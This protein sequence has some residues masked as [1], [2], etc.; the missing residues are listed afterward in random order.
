MWEL[1]LKPS[2]SAVWSWKSRPPYLYLFSDVTNVNGQGI[3][4]IKYISF[5][6]FCWAV[7]V[8]LVNLC[9]L[10]CLNNALLYQGI[11]D[12]NSYIALHL[13]NLTS[14]QVFCFL[15]DVVLLYIVVKFVNS[16]F[17]NSLHNLT[18]TYYLG[19]YFLKII[20]LYLE[21]IITS[22]N[23]RVLGWGELLLE[24][25]SKYV[26]LVYHFLA[27]NNMRNNIQ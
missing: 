20:F 25:V 22:F 26:G 9:S 8:C 11:L 21:S 27:R 5:P 16:L 24:N 15:I 6:C 13:L 19:K 18:E 4:R 7:E 3:I 1:C 12:N 2:Y 10:I 14:Y 23:F 17:R